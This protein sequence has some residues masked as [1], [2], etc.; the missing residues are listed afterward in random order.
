MLGSKK[1]IFLSGVVGLSVALHSMLQV[2]LIEQESSDKYSWQPTLHSDSQSQQSSSPGSI[3]WLANSENSTVDVQTGIDIQSPKPHPHAGARYPNGSF[4]YIADVTKVRKYILKTFQ[5]HSG[6]DASEAPPLSYLPLD[7]DQ[8]DVV[9]N[10]GPRERSLERK[11]GW[12][13][14]LRMKVNGLEGRGKRPLPTD[15]KLLCAIYTYEKKHDAVTAIGESWGWRCDGFFAASTKTVLDPASPGL[16]AIDLPHTGLE[17][18]ENMWMKVRSIWAYIHDNYIDDY[19]F[20]YLAGDDSHL[21]VE[22]LRI[23]LD[24][25]GPVAKTEPLYLGQ[26]IPDSKTASGDYFCGG[27]PGYILNKRSLQILVEDIFPK[28][29]ANL[30]THAE[31]RT[32]G[33][34]F[35]KLASIRGNRSV[36]ADGSQMF[37]GMDPH[38]ISHFAGDKGYF[39]RVY[40]FWGK[41]YGYKTGLEL[42]SNH[43]V[44]FHLLKG[45][46]KMK[47]HHAILYKSCPK[48]TVIGDILVGD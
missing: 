43:S 27:G 10:T 13:L 45:P 46:L 4:G 14:L 7:A 5:E 38:F 44:A 32:I 25:M 33:H 41:H 36:D 12:R 18:Y 2:V 11:A 16:G 30:Q 37:H 24:T 1:L 29:L 20:F 21:I 48:G 34:C 23:M 35:R 28:C 19:D 40:D 9:C 22:N 26:W 3:S 47:R 42:A 8:L 6:S 15:S 17:D 31:D 39:K